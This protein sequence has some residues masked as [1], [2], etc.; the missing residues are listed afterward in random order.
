[1]YSPHTL[2]QLLRQVWYAAF[3]VGSAGGACEIHN[4]AATMPL[5]DVAA[6]TASVSNDRG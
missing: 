5:P 4:A 3:A 6:A 2:E 1:M